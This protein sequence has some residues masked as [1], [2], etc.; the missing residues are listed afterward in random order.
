MQ[1]TPDEIDSLT[2]LGNRHL[3]MESLTIEVD[4]CHREDG[5]LALLL[6]DLDG[7]MCVNHAL[8]H[9]EGDKVLQSLARVLASAARPGSTLARIG[10]DEFAV[11]LPQ[12]DLE[13]AAK[14][15]E[16]LRL[17]IENAHA[18][19]PLRKKVEE[20]IELV[21]DRV[22]TMSIGVAVNLPGTEWGAQDLLRVAED[23]MYR[24]KGNGRNQVWA[25]AV[26]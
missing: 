25:R 26:P 20:S 19:S 10:G 22:F 11:L 3:L 12:T 1:N 6:M 15:A 18:G 17:L 13:S 23:R 16:T 8:G 21:C 5:H 14:Y 4:R 24:A 9:D 7:F 2:G